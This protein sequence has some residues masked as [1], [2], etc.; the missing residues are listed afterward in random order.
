MEHTTTV[1]LYLAVP[2]PASALSAAVIGVLI[3]A[4]DVAPAE[5]M[6]SF[7]FTQSGGAEG[8]KAINDITRLEATSEG[9]VI[10]TGASDP[11]LVGPPRDFPAAAPLLMR[12]RLRSKQPGVCQVFYFTDRFAE[13][14]SVRLPVL[15]PGEWEELEAVLPALGPKCRLRIDPPGS[16]S[17]VVIAGL[18][19]TRLAAL[20]EPAWPKPGPPALPKNAF[21]VKSGDL[22]L[23]HARD[24]FGAF[25]LRVKGKDMACG[26]TRPLLGCLREGEACWIDLAQVARAEV[27]KRGGKVTATLAFTDAGGAQWNIEQSF[28]EGKADGVIDVQTRVT[29]SRDRDVFYLPLLVVLPGV[30][31]FGERKG[32]GLFAGLEYLEDEPSSSE[33]DLVGPAARRQVPDSLKITFP[34]MAIQQGGCYAGLAWHKNGN[35]DRFSALFDSPDRLFRSG[36]HVMGL[37]FP[38]SNGRNR[39]EGS[40]LPHRA[41]RISAQEPLV[42]NATLTGGVGDSVV[43][44]V[45]QYVA[46]RGLPPVPEALDFQAYVSLAAAGW[47]DSKIRE[48][49]LVRH[50]VWSGFNAQAAADAA[51]WMDWLA[52]QTTQHALAQRLRAAAQ[53]SLAKVEPAAYNAAAVSH[54]RYPAGSLCYGYVPENAASA[55]VHARGLLKEFE[56][57]GTV[58]YRKRKEVDFGRTHWEPQAN[59]L[60]GQKVAALLE[61]ACVSGD[62]DLVRE[63]LRVLRALGRFDRTVPRGA[64]TW[65]IPLHTP[66]ILAS[67]HL[68]KAYTRGYELTG[69]QEFLDR[70][71]YW[72]WTGVPF[73]YLD[74]PTPQPVGAYA[75]IAVLGATN[76]R[77][78]VWFG[79]PVQ[80]CGLVYADA[81][82]GLASHAPRGP[83]KQLA[84][85]ITACGIQFTWTQQDRDRQGLLPDF[86]HLRQQLNDGPAINPGTVQANAVRLF[87][88]PPV[89]SFRASRSNSCF[90]HAPGAVSAVKERPGR[91]SFE[92][93]SWLAGPY[94][95]LISG[96]RAKPRVRLNG[97]DAPLDPPHQYAEQNGWLVLRLQGATKIEVSWP[98]TSG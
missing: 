22:Q 80:W 6:P 24:A 28:A 84:D 10:E 49:V 23:L 63:G 83:W 32:Q 44:A 4:G 92:V 40:L 35:S 29:V 89:Y 66:D 33:A 38:G 53:E 8:W 34:L 2:L 86:Y 47:L 73:V 95:V 31:S 94:Y 57:D 14:H 52:G 19:F 16:G 91:L 15:K 72:A 90:V 36:G 48:G 25:S 78:P 69:E 76:W 3:V 88:Q 51:Y 61:L 27:R 37:L 75:T 50:A 58:L 12:V 85:G 98:R 42:L 60:A 1:R 55:A 21:A 74:K 79:Q 87:N 20:E 81:L 54:V 7:D 9:L 93:R 62:Q 11:Y 26:Q 41:E 43:P 64:Q 30:G 97:E 65:E 96:L 18:W 59:G 17:T 39:T 67:A 70:A 68:V 46:W 77:A 13:E 82:Y 56:P 71:V 45:Q 5:E